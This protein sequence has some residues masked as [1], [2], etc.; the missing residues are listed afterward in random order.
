VKENAIEKLLWSI[1]LPGFGQLLNGN[2]IKGILLISLELIVNVQSNFN[3]VI[4]LSFN[5]NIQ[6]AVVKADY[7]W[8]MF[9][10]CLYFFAAWD[11][12]KDAKGT[13]IDYS[14]FPYVFA[15]YFVTVGLIY[16]SSFKIFGWILGPV[17]FPILCVIP[18]V[19]VGLLIQ[20]ILKFVIK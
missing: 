4:L 18:G 19:F 5:G 14:Y 13:Q 6:E 8:L 3:K 12:Y 17:F 15:A 7:Q 1:A 10:P 20:N 9:Y 2:Y 11:A 16:S